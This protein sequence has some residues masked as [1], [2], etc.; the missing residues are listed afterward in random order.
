VTY[1]EAKRICEEDN[2]ALIALDNPAE[3]KKIS[4][5]MHYIGTHII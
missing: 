1:K 2:M 5:Y 4:D 3:T